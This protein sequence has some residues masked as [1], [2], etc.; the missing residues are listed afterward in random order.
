[1]WQTLGLKVSTQDCSG[2]S[3]PREE[4]SWHR[5]SCIAASHSEQGCGFAGLVSLVYLAWGG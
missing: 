3:S 4:A 5:S 2:C 1:M